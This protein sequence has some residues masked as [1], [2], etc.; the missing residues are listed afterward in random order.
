MLREYFLLEYKDLVKDMRMKFSLERIIDDFIFFCFFIGNDFLPTLFGLDI[1]VASLDRM[2]EFYK[3]CLPTMT[4]YITHN[5][6]IYWDRAAP[7]LAKLG[8][9]EETKNQLTLDHKANYYQSKVK[10]D[11]STHQG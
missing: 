1:A 6:T 5:G 2:I 7:F 3:K 11:V 8:S 10:I 9:H 4:D